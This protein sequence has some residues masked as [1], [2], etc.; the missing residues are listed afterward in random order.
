MEIPGTMS[1]VHSTPI[2]PASG[3]WTARIY[4]ALPG[5][6]CHSWLSRRYCQ[7]RNRPFFVGQSLR[8][9]PM[10]MPKRVCS[11]LAITNEMIIPPIA[12]HLSYVDV[13]ISHNPCSSSN[14]LQLDSNVDVHCL[15]LSVPMNKVKASEG[16]KFRFQPEWHLRV[17]SV[18]PEFT[19]SPGL[20]VPTE[21]KAV[22]NCIGAVDLCNVRFD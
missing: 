1:V 19:S 14:L 13:R 6:V 4:A 15:D 3:R 2:P 17:D 7:P 10:Q 21:G 11:P 12:I 5:F 22:L 9:I 20:F 18:F 16:D 8:S